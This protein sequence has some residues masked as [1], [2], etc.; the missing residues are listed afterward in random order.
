MQESPQ[1]CLSQR[2][3]GI[4]KQ[5]MTQPHTKAR[6][7]IDVPFKDGDIIALPTDQMHYLLRVLRLGVGAPIAVFNGVDGEFLATVIE[8]V[9]KQC[10]VRIGTRLRPQIHCRDLWLF[11]APV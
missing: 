2:Y 6:L 1:D 7:Y 10:L 9:K 8:A 3:K 11:F 4:T 5:N